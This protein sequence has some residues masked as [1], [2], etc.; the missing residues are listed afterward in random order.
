MAPSPVLR[1]NSGAF[2]GMVDPVIESTVVMKALPEPRP[3]DAML[4][5]ELNRTALV[6]RR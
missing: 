6:R 3:N 5:V 4:P 1:G 2:T